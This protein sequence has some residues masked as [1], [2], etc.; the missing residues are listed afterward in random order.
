MIEMRWIEY[1]EI[2]TIGT[3][4]IGQKKTKLQYRQITRY[5]D[6][7]RWSEWVDVP[8]TKEEK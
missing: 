2:N 3:F 5:I 8:T 4:T 7:E 1:E 6:G